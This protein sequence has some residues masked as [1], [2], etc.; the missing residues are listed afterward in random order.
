[1]T[2]KIIQWNMNGFKF[3]SSELIFIAGLH[4][5]LVPALQGTNPRTE[6]FL[7][8]RG[9]HAI[10]KE[11][12]NTNKLSGGVA[13]LVKQDLVY[14]EVHLITNLKAVAI[15][16]YL[17]DRLA[18][19]CKLYLAPSVVVTENK[20]EELLTQLPQPVFIVGN[21]NAL[22]PEWGSHYYGQRIIM[23]E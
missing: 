15:K 11:R 19:I 13:I 21:F 16:M 4:K 5:P 3:K 7:Q 10:R 22:A 6:D 1:M 17:T 8:F 12:V 2:H 18:T 20:L 9:F 14:E 23:V